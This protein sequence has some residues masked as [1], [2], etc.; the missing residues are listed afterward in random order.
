MIAIRHT[1]RGPTTLV[2]T[3][4]VTGGTGTIGARVAE[5]LWDRG[6]A[7]R[8]GHRGAAPPFDWADPRSWGPALEGAAGAFVAYQPDLAAPEA[9][10]RVGAF[11]REAVRRGA[12]RLVLLSSLRAPGARRAEAALAASGAAWTVLRAS[13]PAQAFTEGPLALRLPAIARALTGGGA[14]EPF[15]DAGDVAE[16]AATALLDGAW[17]GRAL[18]I[19]GPRALTPREAAAE[20]AAILGRGATR[21]RTKAPGAASTSLPA[22]LAA[23]ADGPDLAPTTTLATLLGR[24]ARDLRDVAMAARD[25]IEPPSTEARAGRR[26]AQGER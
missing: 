13:A 22:W 12:R 5:R 11:A 1:P 17:L 23:L 7:V 25:R 6:G 10:W 15:V 4:L 24:P 21:S 3:T 14:R 8:L 9:A 20:A 26:A 16:V 19:T 18:E 2:R